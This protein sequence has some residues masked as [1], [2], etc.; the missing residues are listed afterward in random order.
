M[1]VEQRPHPVLLD[2]LHEQVGDPVGEVEVVRAARL[3]AG[4]VAQVEEVLDVGV[5]G[6]EVDAGRAFA[7]AALVDRGDRA[8]EGLQPRDDAVGQTVGAADER[9]LR[10]HAVIGEADAAGEL[11][12]LRDVGVAVVD[13]ARGR[14]RVSRAGS[15]ST[16]AGARCPS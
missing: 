9:A 3:V 10:P 16:S 7:L 12:E 11:R 15:S 4:V 8:V 5:P 1:R 13:G 2:A 6:L 14:R